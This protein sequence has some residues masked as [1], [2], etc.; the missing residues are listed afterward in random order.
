MEGLVIVFAHGAGAPSSSPWMK[1]WARHLSTLGTTVPF[2]YP[3]MKAGR[4]APDKLP[5]LIEAHR[6][7]IAEAE[8]A[9]PGPLVLA[10]KSMGSRVG[11]HVSLTEN[12]VRALVCFGYPLKGAGKTGAVRDEVLLSL[13]APILFVAGT[14]DPLCPLDLLALVRKRMKAQSSL[15]VVE[16]GDHSL[17]VSASALKASKKTQDDVDRE[18]LSAVRR[19]LG[20]VL[21]PPAGLTPP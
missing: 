18:I 19:F 7:A 14:R 13:S 21:G 3:Y 16:G 20:E 17:A 8:A 10:G 11:C 12:R 6:R 2:D 4:R 9:H 15:F 5:Q 1:K